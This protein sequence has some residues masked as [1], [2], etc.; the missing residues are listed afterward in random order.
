[1]N[2][3]DFC[4]LNISLDMNRPSPPLRLRHLEIL[5]EV[6]AVKSV[7]Q[8][9][10]NLNMAQPGVTRVLRELEALCG[11]P[12]VERDGRSIRLTEHGRIF[13]RHS[14]S[15]LAAVRNGFAAMGQPNT[16]DVPPLRVGALPT[17]SAA[18]MPEVVS[19]YTDAG[20]WAPLVIV[21]GA[22]QVLL[23]QLRKGELDLVFGR[24][25]D[26][27]L[28]VGLKFEPVY[29]ERVVF[30][31]AAGHPLLKEG[32]AGSAQL[33]N[34]PILMP[35]TNAIIRPAVEWVFL[36]LGLAQPQMRIESV[37]DSFGRAFVKRHRAVWVISHGVVAGELKSGEFAELPFDTRT[38]LG[39]VGINVRAGGEA[40]PASELFLSVFRKAAEQYVPGLLR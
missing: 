34:W 6:A 5:N 10:R 24:L 9:A 27:E 36:E 39:S 2:N 40:H 30:V 37:S 4:I 17:V 13:A 31:V 14:A 22:N 15:A 29:Q 11:Y 16:G 35:T 23:D 1:M 20:G 38:T 12:L 18:V 32:R 3:N 8:A 28:M 26:P 33:A 19:A 25:P 7:S 21:T